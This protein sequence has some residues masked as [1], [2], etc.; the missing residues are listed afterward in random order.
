LDEEIAAY[1]VLAQE[2]GF[3]SVQLCML[4]WLVNG[5]NSP[6]HLQKGV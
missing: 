5:A 1:A 2:N 6:V 3:G 4:P